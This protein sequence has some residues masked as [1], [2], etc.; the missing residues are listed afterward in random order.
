MRDYAILFAY[1]F[2]ESKPKLAHEIRGWLVRIVQRRVRLQRYIIATFRL[3]DYI[4]KIRIAGR[5]LFE[6]LTCCR[7]IFDLFTCLS[8]TWGCASL[9]W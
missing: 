3:Q 8:L 2:F 7:V 4:T 6:F 9:R 5:L 1:I